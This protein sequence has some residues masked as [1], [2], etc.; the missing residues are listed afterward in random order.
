[1]KLQADVPHGTLDYPFQV[2]ETLCKDG[3]YLYPHVHPEY[4]MTLITEGCGNF[5]IDGNVFRVKA[6]DCLFIAPNQI[7]L[8]DSDSKTD[9]SSFISIVFH[10]QCFC[11]EKNNIIYNKYILPF[12]EGALRSVPLFSVGD[13]YQEEI[14]K[15][16]L[17]IRDLYF[18][19]DPELFCQSCMLKLWFYIYKKAQVVNNLQTNHAAHILKDTIDYMQQ[20]FTEHFTV[21]NLAARVNLSPSH[22]SRIFTHYMHTSP[23]D[24]LIKIRLQQ[25]TELLKDKS[26]SISEIAFKCGFNDFSYFSKCFRQRYDCSPREYRGRNYEI[27]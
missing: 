22:F 11:G 9:K 24:Y 26:V 23:I 27:L 20:N 17:E 12:E 16:V 21:A 5:Y 18:Q 10:P 1:M 19:K 8:A 2:H 14:K 4:E 7:H 15:L 3:L 6:G 13:E 25:S